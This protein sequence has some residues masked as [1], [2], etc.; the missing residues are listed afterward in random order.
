MQDKN[1]IYSCIRGEAEAWQRFVQR[2]SG[3]VAWSIRERLTK[4]GYAF[5][6]SDVEDIHQE[7]FLSIYHNNKLKQLKDI[8]KITAW[9]SIIAGNIA[10]NYIK[11]VKGRLSEKSVS[12]FEKIEPDL[13]VADTLESH[14]PNAREQVDKKLTSET[15]AKI[16]E[17]LNPKEKI[18]LNLYFTYENTIEEIAQLVNL[19][20][21]T[22]A[23]IITRT[24]KKIKERLKY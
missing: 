14:S 4:S 13:T 2:F 20:Q 23:S 22:V 17:S 11:R 7:T 1:I 21:G 9:V 8:S 5:T 10:I 19:A 16:I 18:I 6:N 24:K 15:L 3:L 12:L